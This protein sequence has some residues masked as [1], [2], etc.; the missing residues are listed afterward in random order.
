MTEEKFDK[1]KKIIN[2]RFDFKSE[3]D[4]L[5][6]SRTSVQFHQLV[7]DLMV[8]ETLELKKL[9]LKKDELF[10]EK[11]KYYNEDY[12]RKKL[13]PKDIGVYISADKDYYKLSYEYERVKTIADYLERT[14]DNIKRS[15][16]QIKNYIEMKKFMN[17]VY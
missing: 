6:F 9:S 3:K 12:N 4:T 1:I 15:S 14:I 16:F 17:G 7:L 8:K 10:S 5:E 13:S 11:F 2:D